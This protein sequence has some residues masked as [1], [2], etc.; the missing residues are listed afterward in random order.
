MFYFKM[1]NIVGK[2][3]I[4]IILI[5]AAVSKLNGK[6]NPKKRLIEDIGCTYKDPNQLLMEN[7]C[8]IAEYHNSEPPENTEDGNTIVYF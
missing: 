4:W 5:K 2:F 3:A 1:L 6:N 7:V 8:K